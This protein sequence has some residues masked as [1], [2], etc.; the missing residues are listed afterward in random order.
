[1]FDYQRVNTSFSWERI[2]SLAAGVLSDLYCLPGL[3]AGEM[4]NMIDDLDDSVCLLSLA[5]SQCSESLKTQQQRLSKG[6]NTWQFLAGT[7]SLG[8]LKAMGASESVPVPTLFG[9]PSPVKC[10]WQREGRRVVCVF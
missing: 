4:W 10:L 9:G 1:M 2:P 6:F 3:V 5:E 8:S 7:C